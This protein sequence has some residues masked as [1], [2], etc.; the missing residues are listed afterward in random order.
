MVWLNTRSV[1]SN[2]MFGALFTVRCGVRQR[3]INHYI[4]LFDVYMDF[5]L[6]DKLL[7][8]WYGFHRGSL[9]ADAHL[10]ADDITGC[11]NHSFS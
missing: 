9:F 11:R 1:S 2:F 3:G 4:L 6:V 8:S 10:Y 7:K 5:C